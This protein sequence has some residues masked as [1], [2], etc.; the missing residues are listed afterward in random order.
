MRPDGKT[1]FHHAAEDG[2]EDFMKF[3]LDHQ[4]L[5]SKHIYLGYDFGHDEGH[6]TSMGIARIWG[7]IKIVDLLKAHSIFEV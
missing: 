2:D 7:H 5:D 3:L 6:Q 1:L 4:D